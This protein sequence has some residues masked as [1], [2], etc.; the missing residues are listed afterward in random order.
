MDGKY[1]RMTPSSQDN[2]GGVRH[3]NGDIQISN[4]A[5]QSHGRIIPFHIHANE[6][7]RRVSRVLN[8]RHIHT[9][10]F[11]YAW[12]GNN[13]SDCFKG[14]IPMSFISTRVHGRTTT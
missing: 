3:G 9:R 14:T 10:H 11:V 5:S 8:S 6:S 13:G 4:Y 12:N 7:G 2:I 1:S